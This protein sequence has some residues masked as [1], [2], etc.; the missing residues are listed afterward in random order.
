MRVIGLDIEKRPVVYTSFIQ[1]TERFNSDENIEYMGRL[2]E[3]TYAKT[4]RGQFDKRITSDAKQLQ[5]IW[6][7]DF[8][9][10]GLRDQ[11]PRS[12]KRRTCAKK[13]NS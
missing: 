7:V 12:G 9:G 3:A 13:K 11:N 4:I 1:A 5:W 10:F 8:Y 6:V 2:L